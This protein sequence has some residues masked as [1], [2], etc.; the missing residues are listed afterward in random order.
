MLY[1]KYKMPIRPD[2][3]P[4]PLPLLRDAL[5]L[6]LLLLLRARAALVP[7]LLLL[8]TTPNLAPAGLA[9][10]LGKSRC[11]VT[12]SGNIFEVSGLM[13]WPYRT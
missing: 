4:L 3:I 7:L 11:V 6:L 10:V 2:P 1:D 8:H 5:L 9:L 12:S 13:C